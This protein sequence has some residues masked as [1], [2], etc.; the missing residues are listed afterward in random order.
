M[1]DVDRILVEAMKLSDED[2]AKLA[3]RLLEIVPEEPDAAVEAAWMKE[4]L[5]RRAEWKA[6]RV[7]A[8]PVEE[9]L[10]RMFAKP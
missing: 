7:K 8:I 5:R 4:V 3:Y 2:R 1:M 9:A 10:T 6:G